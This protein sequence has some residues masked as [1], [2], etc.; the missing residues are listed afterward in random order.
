MSGFRD[1][2]TAEML[3][4]QQVHLYCRGVIEGEAQQFG[5]TM[6][7]QFDLFGLDGA[8]LYNS[9]GEAWTLEE[10]SSTSL[11]INPRN[12]QVAKARKWAEALLN[13]S[14]ENWGGADVA[15]QVVDKWATANIIIKPNGFNS[16]GEIWPYGQVSQ[17]APA[18]PAVHPGGIAPPAAGSPAAGSP[19]A[20]APP[21]PVPPQPR[22][23]VASVAQPRDDDPFL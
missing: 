16:I 23:T 5:P 11:S 19:V 21:A 4:P 8:P 12:G 6:R 2:G 3:D 22:P 7:W 13:V 10:M 17:A 14:I 18:A 9:N 15:A 1:P 20:V